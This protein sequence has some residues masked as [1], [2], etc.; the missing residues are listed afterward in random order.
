MTTHRRRP[1]LLPLLLVGLSAHRDQREEQLGDLEE[2]F[3]ERAAGDERAAA[4]WYW[5]QAL[6]SVKPNLGHR[7][8]HLRK[9]MTGGDPMIWTLLRDLRLALR[10]ARRNPAFS[11]ILVLTLALG[12]GATTT[13]FSAVYGLVLNPFPFP[14]PGR[15]VGVGT[16]YPKLGGELAFWEN[17]S[18]AEYLDVKE[19]SRT[20]ED[21]VAWDMGNRQIAGEGPPQNVFTAFW[22]GD[23]L[24]TLGMKAYLGRGFS[25]DEVARGDPVALLS[26][27]IWRDRFGADS[28][29]VGRKILVNGNPHT[30][31]GILPP[32]VEI[33][34]TDLWTIMP[35]QPDRYPR[36][37]RQFQLMARIRSGSTLHEV[38]TELAGL[39]RRTEQAYGAEFEE[40]AGWSM[41]AMTWSHVASRPFRSAAFILFG[42]VGFVL[43]LVC[44]NTANLLLARG[45]VRRHEMAVRTAL[46]AGRSRLVIQLLVES[47]TLALLGG[48]GGLGF[49]YLGSAGI[50]ALLATLALPVAGTVGLNG[51]VL[52]FTAAVSLGAG[53]LFGLMPAFQG[54]RAGIAGVLQAEGRRTTAGVSRQRLQRTLVAA[55]VTLAFV[56]LAG[57]GL[58]I[59]SFVRLSRVDPGFAPQNVLTMRLTLPREKYSGEAVPA[60]FG[61]L[62]ERLRAVPGIRSAAAGTQFPPISFSFREI[63]FEGR[64]V[65]GDDAT[66]PRALTT[67]VT[68]GYFSTLGIPLRRGRVL[69]DRD[70]AG[71]PLV[72]VINE[73]AARR[74]FPDTDPVG[75]RLKIGG[76]DA[77]TP[78]WEIV[79][80][81]GSTRNRGL[82]RPPQPEIFAAHDQV[83]ANQNQ[84][85]LL[86]RTAVPPRSVLPAVR[87]VIHDMDPDQPVYAIQTVDD[88]FAQAVASRRATT[89]FLSI[90][91]V[92][93]LILAAVGIYGVVSFTVNERT[94]EIGLRMALGA[95]APRVR[96]LVVRQA[97]VPVLVGALL[98]VGLVI[99]LGAVLES[100]LFQVRGSDPFTLGSVTLALVGV[101]ALASF[102]PA[103][104]ASRVDPVDALR[105]E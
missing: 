71:S 10:G 45:H 23:A 17:L 32:G 43:L 25:D 105:I 1:P 29:M 39:A 79:G 47:L 84:L 58:L 92:F 64:T 59:N 7:V 9:T 100:L 91:G 77:D 11:G 65:A 12:I 22:W 5:K 33:Y 70:R 63:S 24:R 20:L 76:P 88:A 96:G 13:V 86:I 81:V 3:H 75:K 98:G 42:A 104:R 19:Q 6:A 2:E 85:F 55:E 48:V 8:R 101:A 36:N 69:N 26:Y 62:S 37:R 54:S 78:W 67:V 56:L 89:L 97:L 28:M 21:V 72:A 35:I 27:R 34:G 99:P 50:R 16:E 14:E 31:V 87:G 46:G 95:A 60:F 52:A 83:G 41:R 82:D 90:F 49:A 66:L 53:V 103:W 80:V 15:I 102:V 61:E 38:N 40:Y 4:R 73:A 44:A 68:P 94:R 74:W 57:S 18:P 30:L 51:P 93:A